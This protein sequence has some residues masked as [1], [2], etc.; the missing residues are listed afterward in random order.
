MKTT[1]YDVAREANVSI[2][3][4]SKVLNN[5]GR[6]GEETRGKVMEIIKK[7]NYQPNKMAS[8]LTG[9]Q[10]YSIGLLIPDLAN[11]FFAE[12]ARS[13]E[14]QGHQLGYH[15]IICSTDYNPQKEQKYVDLLKRNKADG[16]ILASGFEQSNIIEQLINEQIP[17][18]VVARDLPIPIVNT[19]SNDDFYGGYQAAK[20]LIDLGHKKIAVIAR[21]VWTNRQRLDGY[22]KALSDANIHYEFP[23]EYI[24]ESTIEWGKEMATHY[25]QSADPPTAIF[26]C[27]DLLA[28]GAIQAIKEKGLKVPD[29]ISV[30]G[31]DN[32]MIANIADPPLTTIAQST[33]NM[34]KH[35]MDL[36]NKEITE[37]ITDKT[38]LA[39]LPKLITRKS[40]KS[41]R[42]LS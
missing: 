29:D 23:F 22:N 42:T 38:R 18:A 20:H 30:V 7:L 5:S 4:V 24:R 32:T 10:T 11:P 31:F 13:I 17:V 12:L 33:K 8:A 15:L 37:G 3:T 14:D 25:L 2:A 1:I 40:T 28:I 9:K 19:V 27:N 39:L 21:D 6:I 16:I 35:V 26:A 41:I 34:G 36:I